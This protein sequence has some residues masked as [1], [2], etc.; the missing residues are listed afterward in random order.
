MKISFLITFYNQEDY[1]KNSLDSILN[2]DKSIDWEI[3][4]GDDG[5]SDN[6][7][8]NIQP[9]LKAYPNN[10]YLYIMPRDFNKRYDSVKR[11]SANRLNLLK[12]SKGDFFCILDGDDYF[13]DRDF[14][15]IAI[16]KFIRDT[17]ISVVAFRHKIVC[18]HSEYKEVSSCCYVNE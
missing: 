7:I 1:V 18:C 8:E 15:N 16:D 12:H 14:V 6:T 4:V 17:S 5:S 3:L 2:I 11:A 9:Y 10:I 13:C